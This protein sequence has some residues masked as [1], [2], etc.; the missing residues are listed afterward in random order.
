VQAIHHAIDVVGPHLEPGHDE[1]EV[2]VD[3]AAVE[4]EGHGPERSRE[5]AIHVRTVVAT[6]HKPR[7][8]E[9]RHRESYPRVQPFHGATMRPPTS[10]AFTA[11]QLVS[12]GGRVLVAPRPARCVPITRRHGGTSDQASPITVATFAPR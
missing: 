10:G 5:P 2:V 4:T 9:R 8:R 7:D 11:D 6:P 12:A 3:V 1:P